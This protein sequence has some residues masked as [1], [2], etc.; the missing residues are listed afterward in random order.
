MRNKRYSKYIGSITSVCVVICFVCAVVAIMG[1]NTK[2]I[3]TNKS[4]DSNSAV[5]MYAS[6]GTNIF[7]NKKVDIS[8]V[9]LDKSLQMQVSGE[10]NT[11]RLDQV[12][13]LIAKYN[14]PTQYQNEISRLIAKGYKETNVLIAFE[15]L[16][17]NF[18][19]ISE[20]EPLLKLQKT[21]KNWSIVFQEY[22]K[23]I[24][25]KKPRDFSNKYINDLLTVKK[26]SMDDLLIAD[27]I[28]RRGISTFEK[29][30]DYREKGMLWKNINLRLGVISVSSKM[31]RIA[32][33]D[34]QI[35]KYTKSG[36]INTEQVVLAATIAEKT[37]MDMEKVIKAIK[38][39]KNKEE[40]YGMAY[41]EK[42]K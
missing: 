27:N 26:L 10:G 39:G 25:A 20:M 4:N 21:V 18:G 38:Q 6:K 19:L 23:K 24:E 33:S 11:K 36:D 30:I 13:N 16:N 31:P 9:S 35:G 34:A 14:V 40:I 42:Y 41:T 15:F 1:I 32:L 28:S 37:D 12:K 2:K 29:L 3:S 8:K 7:A 17:Q 5:T 22:T